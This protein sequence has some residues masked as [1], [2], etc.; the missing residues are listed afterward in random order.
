MLPYSLICDVFYI[1]SLITL[2]I[3]TSWIILLS[4]QYITFHSWLSTHQKQPITLRIYCITKWGKR[5]VFIANMGN[6][7]KLLR[8][9]IWTML[10]ATYIY[11]ITRFL[12]N[13][14]IYVNKQFSVWSFRPSHW[15]VPESG[16]DICISTNIHGIS[17]LQC[18]ID[19]IHVGLSKAIFIWW[20]YVNIF[21][22]DT[23]IVERLHIG[24]SRWKGI[25]Q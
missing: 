17:K 25:R 1:V 14:N 22:F 10:L 21:L 19:M 4:N 3:K 13:C 6:S 12:C 9:M 16:D 11:F 5:F 2:K 7:P 23:A 8:H 20:N 15:K 18:I 24:V